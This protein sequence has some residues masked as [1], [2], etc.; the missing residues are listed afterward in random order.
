VNLQVDGLDN[1]NNYTIKYSINGKDSTIRGNPKYTFPLE[2]TSN[3]GSKIAIVG[4]YGGEVIRYYDTKE[5]VMKDME[6][7]LVV[8]P[9]RVSFEDIRSLEGV[10]VSIRAGHRFYA[11]LGRGKYMKDLPELPQVDIFDEAGRDVTAQ[12]LD[13]VEKGSEPYSFDIKFKIVKIPKKG[14]VVRLTVTVMGEKEE[15]G[16]F[17]LIP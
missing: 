10:S 1:T 16:L 11:Y 17:T 8:G 7:A 15:S 5:K 9:P 3:Q 6:I 14:I 12:F 4:Y 13:K 2:L